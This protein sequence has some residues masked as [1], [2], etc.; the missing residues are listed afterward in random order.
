MDGVVEEN[1]QQS[2]FAEEDSDDSSFD[3]C[4][5]RAFNMFDII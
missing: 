2:L 5:L 1:D 3:Y 4:Y